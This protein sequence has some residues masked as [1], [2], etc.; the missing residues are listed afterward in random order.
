VEV[1][2]EFVKSSRVVKSD[3][4]VPD[5][6]LNSYPDRLLGKVLKRLVKERLKNQSYN[7][8]VYTP[9]R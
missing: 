1:G 9:Y 2:L 4:P 5:S 8:I 6:T 3:V 7:L